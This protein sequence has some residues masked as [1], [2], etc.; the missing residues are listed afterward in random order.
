MSGYIY[1]LI[2]REFIRTREPVYKIGKTTQDEFKRFK[3]YPKNS[4]LIQQIYCE[5]CHGLE[6]EL[7]ELFRV[8]YKQRR[9]F[10]IEYFEGDVKDMVYTI[11]NVW[12]NKDAP[13]MDI[14]DAPTITD[15]LSLLKI[16]H[17]GVITTTYKEM[18]EYYIQWANDDISL[19]KFIGRIRGTRGIVYEKPNV[20]IT[21]DEI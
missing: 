13:V 17:V 7:I 3:Q 18:W 11:F 15:W 10:G 19:S 1:I 16:R 14:E 8:K 20:R 2:E 12:M 5:D 21:I 9:E 6:R 4:K